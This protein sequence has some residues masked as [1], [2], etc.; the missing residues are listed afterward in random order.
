[1]TLIPNDKTP[2]KIRDR[3]IASALALTC[4]V[5][6]GAF[7]ASALHKPYPHLLLLGGCFGLAFGALLGPLIDS[8]GTGLIWGEGAAFLLW[9]L[10]P[11]RAMPLWNNG[12]LPANTM[13]VATRQQ[14]PELVSY[15]ICLGIPVGLTVG[16]RNS[17]KAA[18]DRSP[19]RWTRPIISGCLAGLVSGLVFDRWTLA[20]GFSPILAGVAGLSSLHQ[21][22]VLQTGMTLVLGAVFG[23]LFQRDI[24]SLGS[25]MSWGLGIALTGWFVGPLTLFPLLRSFP[26]D[27]SPASVSNQFGALI[28]QILFGLLLGFTYAGFDRIW[29]LLFIQSDPLYKKPEGPGLHA[30][31]SLLWGA[32]AGLLGGIV[33]GPFMFATGALTVIVGTGAHLSLQMAT[34]I[35]LTVSTLI[36]TFFGV[37]FRNERPSAG[38]GIAWGSLFGLIW[39]YAGVLTFLPL[40]LVGSLDW[41]PKAATM[42]LPSL[43]G[44]LIYGAVSASIFLAF[45]RR[46]A[47]QLSFATSHQKDAEA[48]PTAGAA[49][50]LCLFALGLGILLPMLL[51]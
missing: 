38:L 28:G 23:L 16:I 33:S 46:Q 49:P 51:A 13:L 8:P 11:A 32:G 47:S 7:I 39:W 2:S 3:W 1:M 41:R 34:L 26:L 18:Q 9:L 45:E 48:S 12:A 35:H 5:A 10:L 43:I 31:R 25:S 21:Y 4:G 15:L 44:H 29:V 27:W 42:L 22:A 14:L 37:L 6:G 36:G 30:F 20:G 19:F 24:R 40:V 17:F 50:A